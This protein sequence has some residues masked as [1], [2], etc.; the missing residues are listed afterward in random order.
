MR[1]SRVETSEPACTKRKMLSMNSST[2]CFISSRKYSAMVSAARPTRRRTPG[3]SSIWPNTSAVLAMTPDS[4]ISTHR[5]L[6]SRVRSPT[7][8]NTDTPE[9]SSATRWIISWMI[10]VLP[11]PAPPNMPILPPATYGSSRSITLMPVSNISVLGSSWSKAGAWR[12]IGQRSP[13]PSKSGSSSARPRTLKTCPSVFSPT[14]T[15][16][17]APVLVTGAPLTSPSVGDMAIA[18]TVDSPT[19]WATSQVIVSVASPSVR[20]TVM[21]YWISGRSSGANSTSTTGPIT[22]AIRPVPRLPFELSAMGQCSF[23]KRQAMTAR[24]VPRAPGEQAGPPA[25]MIQGAAAGGPAS[26]EALREAARSLFGGDRCGVEVRVLEVEQTK[27]VAHGRAVHRHVGV[28]GRGLRVRQVV[29]AAGRQRVQAPVALDEFEDRGVVGVGVVD[30]ALL[31]EGGDDQHRDPGAVTEEAGRLDIAGVV[32]AAAL[33]TGDQH[34]RG[35]VQL[36]VGE[37]LVEDVG[38]EPLEQRPGRG[39]GVPVEDEARLDV[40]DRRQGVVRH[41]ALEVGQVLQVAA[42]RGG[43]DRSGVL[44]RV[45]DGAVGGAGVTGDGLVVVLAE[46]APGDPLGRQLVAD[47]LEGL[48]R[49]R[50]RAGGVRGAVGVVA[51]RVVVEQVV[52]ARG[53]VGLGVVRAQVVQDRADAGLARVGAVGEAPARVAVLGEVVVGAR[54][55]V[56]VLDLVGR[57]DQRGAAGVLLVGGV[58]GAG[59]DRVGSGAAHHRLGVVVGDG[60]AV[61]ELLGQRR[62]ARLDV[63]VAHL[64]AA[65]VDRSG[66][67]RA[68]VV[69]GGVGRPDEQVVLAFVDLLPHLVEAVDR[70]AGVGGVRD[71]LGDLVRLVGQVGREA[72]VR[73]ELRQ[74]D[75]V[76]RV[77]LRQGLVRAGLPGA[78]AVG[79]GV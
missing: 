17:G 8:A 27:Q 52:V 43:H 19:C 77:R 61:G 51:R 3:G 24:K 50:E 69:A 66:R 42:L 57:G 68:V 1:P 26:S 6:P 47:G 14:G 5:S 2:S 9:C 65:L 70:V 78:E 36:R 56:G 7:P 39:G 33:V 30:R 11:T 48:R 46:V 10:T 18:R 13:P 49:D 41:V 79:G 32:V 44:E 60:E 72:R 74:P 40:G 38:G 58:G 53:A 28:A 63:V 37:Q 59:H 23:R 15:V 54:R 75:R 55:G 4:L 45:A 71:V 21:A 34:R 25:P 29:E 20:S 35:G 76:G 16:I 67:D 73:H 12:W 31:G 64:E 62:V 22:R